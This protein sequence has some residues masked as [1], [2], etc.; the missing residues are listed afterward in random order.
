LATSLLVTGGAGFIGSHTLIQLIQVGYD[1]TVIDNLANS[2]IESIRR[3]ERIAGSSITFVQG[4][5]CSP[6]D[7]DGVFRTASENGRPF[8]AVIHFAGLKA[9]GDSVAQPLAYYTTNVNGSL[10]LLKAMDDW[11][12]KKIIFSSSAT[13]YG[14]SPVLPYSEGHPIAPTNPYGRTKAMVEQ[15]LNDWVQAG[16]GR[17]AVSLR[18]FNPIGAHESGLIGESPHGRPNNLFPFI[19]QV[20]IGK[21]SV[22]SVFGSDYDTIDGTG[23]RDYIHV[24]DVGSGH[25]SAVQYLADRNGYFV[26]NLGTGRGTSVFELVKAFENT[27]GCAIALEVKGRRPGDIAVAYADVAFTQGELGWKAVKSVE[28]MCADGWR[29]QSTN[30]NGYDA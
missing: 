12:V 18:Y 11:D 21:Q 25:V 26:F 23:V 16:T 3:V 22:L 10:N 24:M 13:V 28:E 17:S 20:A 6:A 8:E 30:A 2:S 7:L 15:V 9:V 5:I 4:D 29:W 27:T 14:E 1:V 19:T